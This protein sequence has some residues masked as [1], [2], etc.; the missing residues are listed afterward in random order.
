MMTPP[1][2]ASSI[3]CSSV[4]TGVAYSCARDCAAA[5]I[6]STTPASS[7][8]ACAAAFRAWMR[9]MR[10]APMSTTLCM[11]F[12]FLSEGDDGAAAH[13]NLA[14]FGQPQRGHAVGVAHLWLGVAMHDVGEVM[15][16][17]AIGLA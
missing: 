17:V 11:V 16:L 12:P 2:D 10:P 1:I 5:S 8:R 9:P 3:A 14:G 7:M 15:D 4:S 13:G 6:A